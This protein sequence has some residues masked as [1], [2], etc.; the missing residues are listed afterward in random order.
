MVLAVLEAG[1]VTVDRF[2]Q[3]EQT[4]EAVGGVEAADAGRQS[5]RGRNALR[6]LRRRDDD[7]VMPPRSRRLG[8]RFEKTAERLPRIAVQLHEHRVG[9]C[10]AVQALGRRSDAFEAGDAA[11]RRS[12][13]APAALH[14][15]IRVG[16]QQNRRLPRIFDG[17]KRSRS[18]RGNTAHL[19]SPSVPQGACPRSG[20]KGDGQ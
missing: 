16:E 8:Q 7:A 10:L 13:G 19:K 6:Q 17:A 1:R 5:C 2:A 11:A 18:A 12:G 15:A 20:G 9:P 14:G 4:L 3:G